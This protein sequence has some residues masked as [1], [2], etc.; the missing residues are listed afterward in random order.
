MNS[1]FFKEASALSWFSWIG[2]SIFPGSPKDPALLESE[3]IQKPLQPGPNGIYPVKCRADRSD[4]YSLFLAN[5]FYPPNHK[6]V[7]KVPPQLIS[8]GIA[9][10]MIVGVEMRDENRN[11]IGCI[12][13]IYVG[14]FQG[15]PMGLVTWMCVAPNW[16]KKGIGTSLLFALY[17]F[18]KPRKIHWWRN[19]GWIRS[20]LPPVWKEDRMV[21]GSLYYQTDTLMKTNIIPFK[22]KLAKWKDL[23]VDQWKQ[24]NPTGILLDDKSSTNTNIFLEVWEANLR[25]NLTGVL[26]L[27]TTF[28]ENRED[29]TSWC[30]IVTWAWSTPVKNEY[31]QAYL[32][33][34]MI[35][36]LPY[37]YYEAPNAMPHLDRGWKY[38]G[39]SSWSCIGLDVGNPVSRSVLP[40]VA[41]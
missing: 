20:P 13:D 8:K 29:S 10:N 11:L 31:E 16:R 36:Q 30:E 19:D 7:L 4:E 3:L 39:S 25:P 35:D 18:S 5:H 14:S 1:H 12:F 21:R 2:R 37:D 38:S 27:Q 15:S 34:S 22:S 26:L 6:L 23:L 9:S 40:L 41:C 33:E 28:E 17:Y 32:I 24:R